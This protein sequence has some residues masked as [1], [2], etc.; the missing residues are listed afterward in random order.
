MQTIRTLIV[1][2]DKRFRQRVK[3]LLST[4]P[5]IEVIGEAADGHEAILKAR[6][7]EPDLILMDVRMSGMNGISA[8]HRL[9]NEMPSLKIII[10][11]LC[12]LQAYKD[13]AIECGADTFVIKKALFDELV[14]AI[15]SAV[16]SSVLEGSKHNE[17]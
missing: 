12:D 6:S 3:T 11:S 15:R 7:L 4:K 9:K 10:L 17:C 2:D 5:D 16:G 14:P 1:D 8:T 13:A